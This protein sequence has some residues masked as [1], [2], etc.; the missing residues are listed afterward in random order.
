MNFETR[1]AQEIR[2]LKRGGCAFIFFAILCSVTVFFLPLD[3][4]IYW[5]STDGKLGFYV[6]SA[7]FVF[8]GLYCLGATWRRKNFY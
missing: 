8:L 1:T 4:S 3:E 6:L 2:Q 7:F 5:F